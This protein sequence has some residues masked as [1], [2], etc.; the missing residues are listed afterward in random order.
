[1]YLYLFCDL[2]FFLVFFLFRD[3][4][5]IYL[6]SV[7]FV[8]ILIGQCVHYICPLKLFNVFQNVMFVDLKYFGQYFVMSSLV[9]FF[10]VI[11]PTLMPSGCFS[12]SDSI[13]QL[14]SFHVGIFLALIVLLLSFKS[15]SLSLKILA[16]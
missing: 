16:F 13:F 3:W 15:L 2:L 4:T 7:I 11:L 8:L 14:H 6:D 10:P 9:S 12:I 1:M 5:L